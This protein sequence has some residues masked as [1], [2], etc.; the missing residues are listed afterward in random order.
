MTKEEDYGIY[1]QTLFIHF[2]TFL[3][4]SKGSL[5]TGNQGG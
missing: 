4:I 1:G 2:K 3:E 5:D